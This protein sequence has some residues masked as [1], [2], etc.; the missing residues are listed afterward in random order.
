MIRSALAAACV[1]LICSAAG[2]SQAPSVFPGGVVNGAS[3]IPANASGGAVA[4]GSIISIFG[5]NLAPSVALASSVPLPSTLNGTNVTVSGFQARLF[6]VSPGQINAQMPW[7]TGATPPH[8]VQLVVQTAFGSSAPVNVQVVTAA[9]GLFSQASNG[10]G[11]GAILNFTAPNTFTLNTPA[12]TINANGIILIYGTGFGLVTPGP[13]AE[14]APGNGERTTVTPTVL[15]GGQQAVVE[16][17]GLAPQFVGLW[18]INARVPSVPE[19]CFLPVQVIFG[20]AISNT[21][22]ISVMNNR[23]NCNTAATGQFGVALNTSVGMASLIKQTSRL[24]GG[25]PVA[26]PPFPDVLVASFRRFSTRLP[27]TDAGQ[28]PVNGGCIVT[29]GAAN[30]FDSA[31]VFLAT[32]RPL[33]AGTMTLAGPFAGSPRTIGPTT[34]GEYQVQLGNNVIAPGTWTLTGSGGADVG[35]FTASVTI[36]TIF[37][38]TNFGMPGGMFSQARPLQATWSCPDPNAQVGAILISLNQPQNLVGLALCSAACSAGQIVIP[39]NVLS[40]LPLSEPNGAALLLILQPDLARSGRIQAT[41][42]DFGLFNYGIVEAGFG[43]TLTQ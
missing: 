6:Y 41:G 21:V 16:F 17:S 29:V 22:T 11:P 30:L 7:V 10:R 42:L 37:T 1:V 35:T 38:V 4:T 39:S 18:Q 36:P 23:Q 28:P 5:S 12:S 8:V 15:I 13:P 9:P 31:G 25:G 26:P 20:N 24:L 3:F 2:F 33:S 14:G 27:M 43:S 19:G 34:I 32:D 40:Q